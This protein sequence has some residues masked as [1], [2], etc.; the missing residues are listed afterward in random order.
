[1]VTPDS[2]R[3]PDTRIGKK[4]FRYFLQ[5]GLPAPELRLEAPIGGGPDWPGYEYIAETL[6]SLFPAIAA[7]TGLDPAAID[8]DTLAERLRN[9][10]VD[11]SGVQMLPVI[12]GAWSRTG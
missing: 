7:A 12:V 4:L 11:E 9:E 8:I 6:R 2:A 5:A 1:M 10:V 3:G